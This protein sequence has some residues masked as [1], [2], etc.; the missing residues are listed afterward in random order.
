[1]ERGWRAARA[2]SRNRKNGWI[3]SRFVLFAAS[4]ENFLAPQIQM[5]ELAIS[6]D[7]DSPFEKRIS[8]NPGKRP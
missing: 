1:M 8:V 5:L 4:R 3:E 7:S 2:E 6:D